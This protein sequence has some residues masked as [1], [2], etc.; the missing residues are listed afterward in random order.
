MI[1]IGGAAGYLAGQLIK[2][3]GFGIF[4]NVLVGI[5]GS[6]FGKL[7]TVLLRINLGNHLVGD[8]LTA[9]LG[10]V[11]LTLIVNWIRSKS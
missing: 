5:A 4:M 1:L 9:T 10:A 6:I 7:L 2:G 8:L 11:V 3:R